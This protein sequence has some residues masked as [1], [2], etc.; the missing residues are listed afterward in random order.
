MKTSA[1]GDGEGLAVEEIQGLYGPF[2][3]PEKLLQQIWLR[4]DFDTRG[5]V[6]ADGRRVEILHPG[7]WNLLGGPD[8][9]DARLRIQ[10]VVTTGDVE[11]HLRAA[12]WRAHGHAG[13]PAYDRVVLHVVLFPG[14]ERYTIGAG[15]G[16]IPVLSLL[17]LLQHDLEEYAADAAVERLANH[18][19]TR[20]HEALAA[21]P[22]ETLRTLLAE[23]AHERWQVKLRYARV[24]IERVGWEEACHQTA[25]EILG[26]RMNRAPMLA[27]ATRWPLASWTGRTPAETD[28]WLDE[29]MGGGDA[30]WRWQAQGIRPANQPRT[31]LRQ[32]S[33]WTAACPRWPERLE[34]VF[35]A[36]S[37][38][39]PASPAHD[40]AARKRLNL[41]ELR[42][43][44]GQLIC[45]GA[46]SGPRLDTLMGDGF[47]PLIAAGGIVAETLA[48]AGWR[49][50][51]TGDV[52]ANWRRL[53][54]Q[55]ERSGERR[56]PLTHG[57]VQGLLGWLLFEEK[58]Q[59]SGN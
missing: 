26:Y 21:L 48:E 3:F 31:R 37:E 51:F 59:S 50:G 30:A 33:R 27:V 34:T 47:W 57:R 4:G 1:G 15:G 29:M 5:A 14:A 44:V 11:L 36:W 16:A 32:Y 52:P 46:V 7:R 19:L 56:E 17:P 10:N 55:L 2:S 54:R 49:H 23:C 8:F 24:R 58:K 12:D 45:G 25:M 9:K 39:V 20:A 13:D 22:A 42:E 38:S 53:L 40:P 41:R 35:R 28:R 43:T 18:P 6:T